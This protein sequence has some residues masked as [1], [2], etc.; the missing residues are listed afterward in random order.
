[1]WNQYRKFWLNNKLT[2]NDKYKYLGCCQTWHFAQYFKKT[3]FLQ[4]LIDKKFYE[5]SHLQNW[6]SN[7][8]YCTE[9]AAATRNAWNLFSCR[10]KTCLLDKRIKVK[11]FKKWLINLMLY[12]ESIRVHYQMLQLSD[13]PN[14]VEFY[15]QSIIFY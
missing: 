12:F 7:F 8:E 11:C 15:N 5:M 14:I 13:N 10:I 9:I 4:L 1:M 3:M 2:N 6:F